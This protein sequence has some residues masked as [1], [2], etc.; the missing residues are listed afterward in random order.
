MIE[1]KDLGGKTALTLTHTG[2]T[3]LENK[4]AHE[5]GWNGGLDDLTQEITA[6]KLRLVRK[7]PVSIQQ[8]FAFSK[9]FG[10]SKGAFLEV[11]QNQ[12]VI[13]SWGKGKV[14]LLLETEDDDQNTSWLEV[15]HEGLESE[16]QQ[17]TQRSEWDS[18]LK[19][20]K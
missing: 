8:L 14:T 7:C 10:E 1:L 9:T 16:T 19:R 11:V 2:F 12:K 4:D 5:G 3:D 15:I 18:L 13:F 6:G 20:V 17:K